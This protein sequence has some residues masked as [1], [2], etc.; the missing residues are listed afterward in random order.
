MREVE[1]VEEVERR[2]RPRSPLPP[3]LVEQ[4]RCRDADVQRL[5]LARKRDRD[6]GVAGAPHQRPQPLSLRP[7]HERQAAG[8]VRLAH[9][10]PARVRGPRPQSRPLHLVQEPREILHDRDGQV[11][12]R[13]RRRARDRRRH[14]RRPVRRQDHAGR[15]RPLGGAAH[16][17]EVPRIR[18]LVETDE[19]WLAGRRELV[20]VRV[21]VRLDACDDALVVARPRELG[22]HPLGDDLRL[23][24]PGLPCGPL[25]REQLEHLAPA[26]QR[27]AHRTPAVDELGASFRDELKPACDVAHFPAR[28]LDLAAEPVCLLEIA[29]RSRFLPPLREPRRS[30][31]RQSVSANEPRPK[32]SS[33]RRNDEFARDPANRGRPPELP[34]C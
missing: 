5:D 6:H 12:H 34:A 13:A 3:R 24:L 20:R 30:P 9:G 18:D 29:P 15:P 1:A 17:T 16:G 28:R 25:G 14:P 22:Q 19:Q 8:Q 31:A 23:P 4:D 32:S 33:P 21:P 7:E 27:L 10:R 2:V 11:L 26:A